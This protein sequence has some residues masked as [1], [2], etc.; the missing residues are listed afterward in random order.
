MKPSTSPTTTPPPPPSSSSSSST[1]SPP[2]RPHH[3]PPSSTTSSS[4]PSPPPSLDAIPDVIVDLSTLICIGGCPECGSI[5]DCVR[6]GDAAAASTAMHRQRRSLEQPPDKRRRG[7]RQRRPRRAVWFSCNSCSR[8][9]DAGDDDGRRPKRGRAAEDTTTN[10]N[11]TTTTTTTVGTMTYEDDV[12]ITR[13]TPN[14]D[15][16]AS[17]YDWKRRLQTMTRDAYAEIIRKEMI[18]DRERFDEE[19]RDIRRKIQ[20]ERRIVFE[21]LKLPL[22]EDDHCDYCDDGGGGGGDGQD[23]RPSTTAALTIQETKE[24]T[25]TATT[26][27]RDGGEFNHNANDKDPFMESILLLRRE[28]PKLEAAVTKLML[29]C[30]R[31]RTPTGDSSAIVD[32]VNDGSRMDHFELSSSAD[33]GGG[34]GDGEEFRLASR[35]RQAGGEMIEIYEKC[36]R[37]S[38]YGG[39][40]G[41][42]E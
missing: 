22:E 26:T 4:S 37:P 2:R 24:K 41:V 42:S 6:V 5:A 7:R 9:F 17:C 16:R 25:T 23:G 40:E 38:K 18:S 27:N 33:A 31:G 36:T 19:V 8:L 20:E 13:M 35:V 34:G 10:T 15:G 21:L 32:V 28:T 14:S 11:T 30:S 3:R 39:K 29:H 1:P 12:D